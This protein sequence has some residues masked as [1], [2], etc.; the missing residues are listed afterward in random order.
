MWKQNKKTM[1]TIYA[2]SKGQGNPVSPYRKDNIKGNLVRD[3]TGVF[4]TVTDVS[5]SLVNSC[6]YVF[7]D[8]GGEYVYDAFLHSKPGHIEYK[9]R[10]L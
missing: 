8:S 7:L 5:V 2:Q 6:K 1:A 10:Y 9:K 3:F 4:G